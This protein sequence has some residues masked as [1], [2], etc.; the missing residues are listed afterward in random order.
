MANN[1]KPVTVKLD[2]EFLN[3]LQPLIDNY[4]NGDRSAC[5][6][7]AL[8]NHLN[9]RK[10]VVQNMPQEVIYAV[11]FILNLV[12]NGGVVR[13]KKLLI[14]EVLRLWEMIKQ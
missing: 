5:I 12:L 7:Q 6:R 2:V 4:Y 13:N 1:V 3:R 10:N 8:E 11:E 14:K 9:D